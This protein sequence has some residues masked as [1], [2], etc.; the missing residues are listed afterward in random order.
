MK[1]VPAFCGS[2][3][4]FDGAAQWHNLRSDSLV[5][6]STSRLAAS[7]ERR[8]RSVASLRAVTSPAASLRGVTSRLAA[9]LE[10]RLQ[11]GRLAPG[12]P[13]KISR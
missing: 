5:R 4:C 13:R 2:G 10:R 12:Y 8:L 11:V 6:G 1:S 7:L 3:S 9:S